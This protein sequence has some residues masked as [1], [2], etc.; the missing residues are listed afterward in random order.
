MHFELL[1]QVH[2]SSFA[3]LRLMYREQYDHALAGS[4]WDAL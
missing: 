3:Y 2:Q 4:A 1:M